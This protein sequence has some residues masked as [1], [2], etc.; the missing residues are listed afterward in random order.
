MARESHIEK[1]NGDD[2]Y[3]SLV[4][5]KYMGSKK[6][7]LPFV[8]AELER[9]TKPGDII[10]DLMAGTHT[11]GYAMKRRCRM[12]ANDIQRYSL[13][14][15][16]TLLNHNPQQRVENP[17]R[18][19][20]KRHYLVNL[21]HLE[22][23]FEEALRMERAFLSPSP[24]R[25]VDWRSYRDFCETYPY[26]MRPKVPA[27]EWDEDFLILFTNQRLEAY[28]TLNKLEPYS[29]FSLYYANSYLGIRQAM[30]VDSLRYAVDK[31]CDEWLLQH[32][33]AGY[34]AFSLRCLLLC[35][36]IAVV[37]RVNPAPGHWAAFQRVNEKSF[38]WLKTQR[39]I[40]L[41]GLFLEKVADFEEALAQNES[42]YSPHI[43]MT[44][45]YVVFMREVQDYIKNARVV[46]LDPPYSQGHYSR[47]YHFIETLVQ[48]DYPLISH[49]GRYRMGR[50]QSPFAH[51]EKVAAAVG[52]VAAITRDAGTTLVISYSHGGIIP[53]AD[54]FRNILRQCYPAKKI[55]VKTLASVHSK[56][57]QPE[58][59]K[60][61]EYL[62]TCRP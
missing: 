13:V 28:R 59:M 43:V 34:D 4:V 2:H 9:L 58:R 45:D 29:L 11:I 54:A 8:T 20:F 24:S 30:E 55:A 46:Y 6:A 48:Y 17:A 15:G 51:K 18:E 53:D 38:P 36:L 35:A 31:L 33:E 14:I 57:G 49:D 56:L 60:T 39:S 10:V 19:A 62:F 27:S 37:N 7:I 40:P 32:E 47:F 12:V 16:Q 42:P 41:L 21:R 25:R 1:N 61:E 52:H 44:E 5:T 23:L 50:H 22:S 26:Y 3:P